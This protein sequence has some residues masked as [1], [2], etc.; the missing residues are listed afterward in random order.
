MVESEVY[1][2]LDELLMAGP[3]PS[4][5]D[6]DDLEAQGVS[7]LVNLTDEPY[8]DDRFEIV[9]LPVGNYMAP[10]LEQI[11]ELCRLVDRAERDHRAV[12]VH[13]IAGCGR[14]GTMMACF[15]VYR[16][17]LTSKAAIARVRELRSCS[18]ESDGQEEVVEVWRR[19][20]EEAGFPDA[21]TM[22]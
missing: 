22:L 1:W 12:Y 14:T 7:V 8:Q 19:T 21:E 4:Q 13:C 5:V 2:L 6:L 16:Q 18:I 17:R 11:V 9:D 3:W 15:L 10:E 20:L